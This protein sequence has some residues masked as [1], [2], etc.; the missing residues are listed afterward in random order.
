[1]SQTAKSK[2][3]KIICLVE[4]TLFVFYLY[5][6]FTG[7]R[8]SNRDCRPYNALNGFHWFNRIGFDI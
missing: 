1:M 4:S 6:G 2:L 5:R 7:E 3:V 8:H